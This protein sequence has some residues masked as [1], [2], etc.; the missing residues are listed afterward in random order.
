LRHRFGIMNERSFIVNSGVTQLIS[1]RERKALVRRTLA[2][3][4]EKDATLRRKPRH[5]AQRDVPV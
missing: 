3:N 2:A 5:S 1:L 4:R